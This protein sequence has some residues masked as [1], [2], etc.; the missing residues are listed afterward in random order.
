MRDLGFRNAGYAN[1]ITLNMKSIWLQKI[2]S[3]RAIFVQWQL[4]YSFISIYIHTH[5][6]S[7]SKTWLLKG[8]Y[9]CY[10]PIIPILW[11]SV[12]LC[13]LT[14]ESNI[15][16]S[17]SLIV[18]VLFFNCECVESTVTNNLNRTMNN[19]WM[20][21]HSIITCCFLFNKFGVLVLSFS[22]VILLSSIF[23]LLYIMFVVSHTW[24]V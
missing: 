23:S 18:P 24:N 12:L 20:T 11:P 2:Y 4:I 6:I 3:Q 14:D 19:S 7:N 13:W 8:E 15:W 9:P 22:S 21:E 10:L 1:Q 17:L 5:M 16:I